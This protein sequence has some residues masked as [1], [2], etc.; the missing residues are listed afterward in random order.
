MFKRIKKLF[1]ILKLLRGVKMNWQ[2]ILDQI[3]S[4]TADLKAGGLKNI[5]SACRKTIPIQE[6]IYDLIDTFTGSNLLTACPPEIKTQLESA[7][8]EC[9]AACSAPLT[10]AGPEGFDFSNIMGII[11][12]IM[13]II[14]FFKK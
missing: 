13:E 4:I 10:A 5:V 11:Q 12:K 2:F 14:A 8:N 9:V 7:C 3:K 6:M 1:R